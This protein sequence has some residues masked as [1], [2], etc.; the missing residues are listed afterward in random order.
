MNSKHT[1]TLP[2]STTVSL[3]GFSNL[4]A[5]K[6]AILIERG[7]PQDFLDIY[8]LCYEGLTTASQCWQLWKAQQRSTAHT[9][10]TIWAKLAILTHIT[11]MAQQH[12][13]EKIAEPIGPSIMPHVQMWFQTDFLEVL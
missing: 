5:Q 3:D 13:P 10:K 9:E 2:S 7:S 1:L 4:V 12:S 11:E 8:T 6:M